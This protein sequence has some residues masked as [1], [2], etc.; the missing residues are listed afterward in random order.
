MT[1][2]SYRGEIAIKLKDQSYILKLTFEQLVKLE[3]ETNKGILKIAKDFSEGNY[4]IHD[5][6]ALLWFS[7]SEEGRKNFTIASLGNLILE[8]G[9]STYASHCIDL[10]SFTLDG[11]TTRTK[12]SI[13]P[14]K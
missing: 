10:L 2:N 7:L 5:I 6:A 4:G 9:L 12:K 3:Q 1:H 13:L 11:A 8:S 14:S